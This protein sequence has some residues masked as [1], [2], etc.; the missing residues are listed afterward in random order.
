MS[1]NDSTSSE[2]D[3]ELME[4]ANYQHDGLYGGLKKRRSPLLEA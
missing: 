4:E 3:E 2:E 1:L